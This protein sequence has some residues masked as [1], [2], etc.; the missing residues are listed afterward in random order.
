MDQ[1]VVLQ[2]LYHEPGKVH[3]AREVA[4]QDGVAHVPAPHRQALAL[5]LLEVAPT[6]DRP[7]GVAGE[8]PPARLHL[9][10]EVREANES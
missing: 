2:G 3:P 8:Y 10:V 5:A 6:H 9:V 1:L 7:P 4:L